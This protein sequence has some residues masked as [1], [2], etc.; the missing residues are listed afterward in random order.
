MAL[1]TTKITFKK[2][3]AGATILGLVAAPSLAHALRLTNTTTGTTNTAATIN[4]T[5]VHTSTTAKA[6]DAT[7]I[8]KTDDTSNGVATREVTETGSVTTSTGATVP[9]TTNTTKTTSVSFESAVTT[10]QSQFS[11]KTIVRAML[12]ANKTSTPVYLVLFSDGSKVVVSGTSGNITFTYDATSKT[13]TGIWPFP[14]QKHSDD[15]DRQAVQQKLAEVS[16]SF[17]ANLNHS[18]R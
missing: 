4:G 5:S 12:L 18:N 10:A 8:G 3:A 15:S 2:L 7:A 13:T 16:Q 11:S 6:T 17:H 9:T 1:Q 14:L